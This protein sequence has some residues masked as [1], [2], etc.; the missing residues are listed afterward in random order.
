MRRADPYNEV[1]WDQNGVLGGSSSFVDE[2]F[3]TYQDI[4][5]QQDLGKDTLDEHDITNT[6]SSFSKLFSWYKGP[7][8]RNDEDEIRIRDRD[9][10]TLDGSKLQK[11]EIIRTFINQSEVVISNRH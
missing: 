1:N 5:G 9:S 8:R 11:Y 7:W 4:D 2:G 6:K 3:S 10:C